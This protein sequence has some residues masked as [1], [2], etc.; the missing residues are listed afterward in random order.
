MGIND[1]FAASLGE[2]TLAH[3]EAGIRVCAVCEHIRVSHVQPCIH[4]VHADRVR[5]LGF[6]LFLLVLVGVSAAMALLINFTDVPDP[7]VVGENG[8]QDVE[9]SEDE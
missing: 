7:R 3:D 5:L 6:S 1:D 8:G 9:A 4:C 2:D